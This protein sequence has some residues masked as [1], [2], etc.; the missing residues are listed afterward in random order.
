MSPYD[1]LLNDIPIDELHEACL[2]L[3]NYGKQR[4]GKTA[5]TTVENKNPFVNLLVAV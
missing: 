2:T 4:M 3:V 5:Q 1:A